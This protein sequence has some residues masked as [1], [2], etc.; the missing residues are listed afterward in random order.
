VSIDGYTQ[1]LI[2]TPET[3]RNLVESAIYS[4]YPDS[5]ITEVDDYTTE[6]PS[7][8]PDDEWDCMGAEFLQANNWVYPIKTYDSFVYQVGP[9]NEEYFKDPMASLMDLCSSLQVG[10][11][12][13]YQIIL[14]PEGFDWVQ[15]EKM[16]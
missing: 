11:Q 15:K 9:S 16:K 5:E 2:R 10:E 7:R 12:L 14:I 13:W 3:F 6:L 1:F 4:Q 8:F